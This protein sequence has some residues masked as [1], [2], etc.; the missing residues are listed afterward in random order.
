MS[1][2]WQE[3]TTPSNIGGKTYHPT[4]NFTVRAVDA[5]GNYI[6]YNKKKNGRQIEEIAY[7]LDLIYNS[8]GLEP[9]SWYIYDDFWWPGSGNP[10]DYL[11]G[12]GWE[13]ETNP[14]SPSGWDTQRKPFTPSLDFNNLVGYNK[15]RGD[16]Y[17]DVANHYNRVSGT[18]SLS[19]IGLLQ[20]LTGTNSN[21]PISNTTMGW[22]MTPTSPSLS[23]LQN[24]NTQFTKDE[25]L[26]GMRIKWCVLCLV[27]NKII[28]YDLWP[29]VFEQITGITKSLDNIN[30]LNEFYL[31]DEFGE[32]LSGAT[33]VGVASTSN[34]SFYVCFGS[35]IRR[36]DSNGVPQAHTGSAYTITGAGSGNITAIS[37][38]DD[39]R[40][41]YIQGGELYK[42]TSTGGSNT[43]VTVRT[44]DPNTSPRTYTTIT[45]FTDVVRNPL[46]SPTEIGGPIKG[47][48]LYSL[49]S[50]AATT[51]YTNPSVIDY[52]TSKGKS[53]KCYN[54]SPLFVPLTRYFAPT[55]ETW[56]TSCRN[57]NLVFYGGSSAQIKGIQK[58]S[59]PVLGSPDFDYYILERYEI[60]S[61]ISGSGLPDGTVSNGTI[62]YPNHSEG[63]T[64]I[65][66]L[67]AVPAF[68]SNT[69]NERGI[70]TPKS[71]NS[72]E[73]IESR[74]S[75][76]II[77][78]D[79][80]PILQ[81]SK[82]ENKKIAVSGSIRHVNYST[83]GL[84][85]VQFVGC[86]AK[87][88]LWT[89][90]VWP[91]EETQSSFNSI[92]R[93]LGVI[94]LPPN[95]SVDSNSDTVIEILLDINEDEIGDDGTIKIICQASDQIEALMADADPPPHP[96]N[97][98][99]ANI[100]SVSVKGDTDYAG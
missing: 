24:N 35:S 31:R 96:T 1:S 3:Q 97:T 87:F 64:L 80:K 75:R 4:T 66:R 71:G 99:I 14:P 15:K 53:F 43:L 23:L 86:L 2:I 59:N 6:F 17:S 22:S 46:S 20:F 73:F 12:P 58:I 90:D 7:N 94:N 93:E 88:S 41:Y 45:G 51:T 62:F 56:D 74:E 78:I 79:V 36:Y 54:P 55:G 65:R 26:N 52:E 40:I 27:D 32:K 60:L 33:C 37:L 100:T 48:K 49:I 95:S 9:L 63:S 69:K 8:V 39:G 47:G 84:G 19:E 16:Q 82:L 98:I 13:L 30:I 25:H 70:S 18:N 42:M 72:D 77:N 38:L 89:G 92:G 91:P 21:N 85:S 61:I 67:S 76:V 83:G 5:S 10:N 68:T 11:N 44:E 57:G 34:A 29:E 28:V 50:S 81:E